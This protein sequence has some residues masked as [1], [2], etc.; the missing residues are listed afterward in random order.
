MKRPLNLSIPLLL[1]LLAWSTPLAKSQDLFGWWP[2]NE[3]T[4]D[5]AND[6]SGN[7]LSAQNT[8]I[9]SEHHRKIQNT[10]KDMVKIKS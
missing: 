3:G 1:G 6:I 5:T 10:R 9:C 2:L 4:G 8:L 7:D